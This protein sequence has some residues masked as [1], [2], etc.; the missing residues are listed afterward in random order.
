[1]L[2]SGITLTDQPCIFPNKAYS[3]IFPNTAHFHLPQQISPLDFLVTFLQIVL[4]QVPSF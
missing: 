3:S 2:D 4:E 1:M